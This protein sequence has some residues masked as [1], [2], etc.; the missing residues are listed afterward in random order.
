MKVRLKTSMV[1][2]Q[3]SLGP[4]KI[5]DTDKY[6]EAFRWVTTGVAEI[7]KE[8]VIETASMDLSQ[9]TPTRKTKKLPK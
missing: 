6:P 1:G 8:D 2:P 5:V 7:V 3:F 4:G 9:E